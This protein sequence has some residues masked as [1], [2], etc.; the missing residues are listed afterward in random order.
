M[1]D[2]DAMEP[3]NDIDDETHYS[4]SE[5]AAMWEEAEPV[6]LKDTSPFVWRVTSSVLVPHPARNVS[7][8]GLAV[9]QSRR[10]LVDAAARR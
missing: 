7:V 10:D 9:R 4:E 1:Q 8:E 5:L 6:S 2:C 3:V